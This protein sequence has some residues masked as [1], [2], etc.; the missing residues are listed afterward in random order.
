[1]FREDPSVASFALGISGVGDWYETNFAANRNLPG[2]LGQRE[3]AAVDMEF[4]GAGTILFVGENGVKTVTARNWSSWDRVTVRSNDP[5]DSG[6]EMGPIERVLVTVDAASVPRGMVVDDIAVLVVDSGFS[7]NPPSAADDFQSILPGQTAPVDFMANDG[8]ADG[9]PI[10]FV[11][12]RNLPSFGHIIVTPH[13]TT[14]RPIARY[15]PAA[16]FLGVDSF[17]YEIT[18]NR[19]TPPGTA[20]GTVRVMVNTPPRGQSQTFVLPHEH[21]LVFH[22]SADE[23]LLSASTDADGHALTIRL[24]SIPRH[25][26]LTLHRDV[27]GL[28]DGSFSFASATRFAT[29][30]FSY[31]VNDGF[32]D[33]DIIHVNLF[34]ENTPPRLLSDLRFTDVGDVP[35]PGVPDPLIGDIAWIDDDGDAVT[36]LIIPDHRPRHGRA[37]VRVVGDQVRVE[38]YPHHGQFAIADEFRVA[39]SDGLAHSFSTIVRVTRGENTPPTAHDDFFVIQNRPIGIADTEPVLFAFPGVA[40][41]DDDVDD[42]FLATVLISGPSHGQL[43]LEEDGR[44][45]YR[46]DRGFSGVDTFIYHADDGSGITSEATV[47]MRV[48]DVRVPTAF[49]DSVLREWDGNLI[50]S[51]ISPEEHTHREYARLCR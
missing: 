14:N 3:V 46:P 47:T 39:V 12:L 15:T 36:P 4:F 38:Y 42:D 9:D 30:S 33:S 19:G 40:W 32:V 22:V 26:T 7:N 28:F 34:V 27:L 24:I 5:S 18:D 10:S 45:I 20:R 44:F 23:G 11:A 50:P 13:P 8:D 37:E 6:A 1:M 48:L 31:V 25:G 43:T 16:G 49:D 17:E 2:G 29:D 51:S 35:A 21:T 41:N